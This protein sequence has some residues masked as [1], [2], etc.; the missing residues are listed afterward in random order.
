MEL[1]TGEQRLENLE[2]EVVA[3]KVM[4]AID[5]VRIQTSIQEIKRKMEPVTAFGEPE[6]PLCELLDK[7]VTDVSEFCAE[8]IQD[9]KAVVD[10]LAAVAS[11]RDTCMQNAAAHKYM[12][13]D[14]E[15][16]SKG[17]TY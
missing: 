14:P 9:V 3:L 16:A 2:R 15:E 4:L 10:R 17:Y 13:P 8:E 6:A 7:T 5:L 11:F 12:Y 1:S